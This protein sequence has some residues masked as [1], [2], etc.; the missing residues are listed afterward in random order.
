M[1]ATA[2]LAGRATL[3]LPERADAR[4]SAPGRRTARALAYVPALGPYSKAVIP[5]EA[6]GAWGAFTIIRISD[7]PIEAPTDQIVAAQVQ[8]S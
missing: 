2:T 7:Y 8:T 4:R 3:D 5:S 6:K 1:V